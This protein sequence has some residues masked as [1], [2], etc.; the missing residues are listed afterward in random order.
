M[1]TERANFTDFKF[2]R[3]L[4]KIATTIFFGSGDQ[5]NK[6]EIRE[7]KIGGSCTLRYLKKS[8]HLKSRTWTDDVI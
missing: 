7:N 2:H 8:T 4:T 6:I 5:K 1:A 3:V